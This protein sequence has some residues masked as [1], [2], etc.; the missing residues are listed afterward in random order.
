[1]TV[2]K[3]T[4]RLD[5]GLFVIAN[6]FNIVTAFV[7]FTRSMNLEHLEYVGL[8]WVGMIAI[9]GVAIVK[10]YLNRRE[11]WTVVLPMLFLVFLVVEVA[12]DYVLN[13]DFR[14]TQLLW[15]YLILFYL[16]QLA[17]IGFSFSAYRKY[18]FLTLAT[19]FGTLLAAWFES[20]SLG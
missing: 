8:I 11:W 1:M 9:V 18:G 16:G 6:L 17:M 7:L 3:K 2:I 14:G 4:Q 19:Y 13:L 12:L 10:N 15:P 5:L 20:M